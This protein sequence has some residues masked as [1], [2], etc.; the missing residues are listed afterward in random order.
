M[1]IKQTTNTN[2]TNFK[3][4]FRVA[5]VTPHI[6]QEF[7][8]YA[9][10]GCKVFYDFSKQ[11]DVLLVAHDRMNQE[12][13]TFLK[14]V[15]DKFT[16]WGNFTP[17]NFRS[18]DWIKT[19]I[20]HSSLPGAVNKTFSLWDCI[21]YKLKDLNDIGA[22]VDTDNA[23]LSMFRGVTRINDM[24]NEKKIYISPHVGNRTFIKIYPYSTLKDAE[25]L[26]C[27]STNFSN[28]PA[29]IIKRYK[30]ADEIMEFDK[31]FNSAKRNY[32]LDFMKNCPEARTKFELLT[33][34][35]YLEEEKLFD[36]VSERYPEI[37]KMFCYEDTF[38]PT[39]AARGCLVGKASTKE[40]FDSYK[41]FLKRD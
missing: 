32:D 22:P 2:N 34:N 33:E 37:A 8:K 24:T 12:I 25:Y 10:D 41:R 18:L 1:N 20:R 38:V 27:E 3:G 5:K 29:R 17:N 40:K 14:K 13:E 11:G 16:F 21:R 28:T 30:T 4:A 26:E 9:K 7:Q 6:N 36:V 39:N 35:N 19:V 23:K 15:C 31:L